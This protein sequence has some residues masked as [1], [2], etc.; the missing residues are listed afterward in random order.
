[1]ENNHLCVHYPYALIRTAQPPT[2]M[3]IHSIAER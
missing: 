1:M 2:V 3:E